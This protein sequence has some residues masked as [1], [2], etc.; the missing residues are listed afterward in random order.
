M[1]MRLLVNAVYIDVRIH[2]I[3]A[4][5]PKPMFRLLFEEVCEGIKVKLL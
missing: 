1:I 5:E 4:I 2:K 3:E